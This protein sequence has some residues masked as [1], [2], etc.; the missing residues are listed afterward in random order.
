ML[1][2]CISYAAQPVDPI[3]GIMLQATY[4]DRYTIVYA[5]EEWPFIVHT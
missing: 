5:M 1:L 4:K 3:S 2:L